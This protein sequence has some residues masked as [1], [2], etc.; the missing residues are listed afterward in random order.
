MELAQVLL[1]K[2]IPTEPIEVPG[3]PSSKV[4]KWLLGP[5]SNPLVRVG[6]CW[7]VCRS[8]YLDTQGSLWSY[9]YVWWPNQSESEPPHPEMRWVDMESWL[10]T[11][12]KPRQNWITCGG[13]SFRM[14]TDGG[15]Q[16]YLQMSYRGFNERNED[17]IIHGPF[18]D[19][20]LKAVAKLI[21]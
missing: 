18:R 4:K 2:G 17:A 13:A 7:E 9:E 15:G 20:L 19:M 11:F 1:R 14:S 5:G 10:E 21:R 3:E 12:A 16:P 6:S 8:F